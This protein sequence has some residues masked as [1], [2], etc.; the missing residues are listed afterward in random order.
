MGPY[1]LYVGDLTASN[2]SGSAV[3]E[4][5]VGTLDLG[6]VFD[7]FTLSLGTSDASFS[8]TFATAA[9]GYVAAVAAAHNFTQSSPIPIPVGNVTVVLQGSLD[10]F[11]WYDL[12]SATT[13]LATLDGSTVIPEVTTAVI[14]EPSPLARYLQAEITLTLTG[15]ESLIVTASNSSFDYSASATV[16]ALTSQISV[17]VATERE[18]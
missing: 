8:P 14:V 18:R 12:L 10:G 13:E 2:G 16:T 15:I 7:K 9:A 1:N 6:E 17:Y 3:T 5:T 4:Q 11:S